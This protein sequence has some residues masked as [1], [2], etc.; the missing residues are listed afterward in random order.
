MDYSIFKESW[1]IEP[2]LSFLDSISI[3]SILFSF[4]YIHVFANLISYR[5]EKST[6]NFW[7]N[8]FSVYIIVKAFT[9]KSIAK[10]N[11][12][13]KAI[14]ILVCPCYYLLSFFTKPPF[15]STSTNMNVYGLL[16]FTIYFR[17][18]SHVNANLCKANEVWQPV[19][20]ISF[21]AKNYLQTD[22]VQR[23]YKLHFLSNAKKYLQVYTNI[24]NWEKKHY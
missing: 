23:K 19:W 14:T 7:A 4:P 1:I 10:E 18:T 3:F 17:K 9:S 24:W 12:C 21:F 16:S 20:C 8:I 5:G 22:E 13:C 15:I 2:L 6:N 11:L